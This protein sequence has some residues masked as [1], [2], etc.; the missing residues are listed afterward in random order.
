MTSDE[1]T[2][3]EGRAAGACS[4]GPRFIHQGRRRAADLQNRSA[5]R[6]MAA[7]GPY[8]E[9]DSPLRRPSALALRAAPAAPRSNRSAGGTPALR[10]RRSACFAQLSRATIPTRPAP[11]API[12]HRQHLSPHAPFLLVAQALLPVLPGHSQE[13]L[14]H[15]VGWR[16]HRQFSGGDCGAHGSSSLDAQ[17][18]HRVKF[19]GARGRQPHG[20]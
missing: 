1:Q 11:P 19:G 14:C 3:L 13:W 15:L 16:G 2:K 5:L 7:A 6:S 8:G 10:P 18:L 9:V 12:H 20:D 17:C 4:L